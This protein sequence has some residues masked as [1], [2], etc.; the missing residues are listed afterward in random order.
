MSRLPRWDSNSHKYQFNRLAFTQLNFEVISSIISTAYDWV[1]K[2]L[3]IEPSP[4][5]STGA[6]DSLQ[7]AAVSRDCN[8]LTLHHWSC[9]CAVWRNRTSLQ[10]A[11]GYSQSDPMVQTPLNFLSSKLSYISELSRDRVWIFLPER[12]MSYIRRI[13]QIRKSS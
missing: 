3:G 8:P 13:A 1:V 10:K 12:R 9:L 5:L 2:D 11:L 6:I 7:T 4:P